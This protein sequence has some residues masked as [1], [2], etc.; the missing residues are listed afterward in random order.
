MGSPQERCVLASLLMVA[1]ESVSVEELKR[2]VWDGDP[3]P[4]AGATLESIVS[5][6]RRR[7]S[8]AGGRV[9]ISFASRAY[10]IEVDPEAVDLL[11]FRRL[12]A[13]ARALAQNGGP[14]AAVDLLVEAEGLWR[15][16]PLGEFDG[17]WAAALRVRFQEERR[18][19]RET[20]IELA[21][22][23]GRH[24]DLLSDLKEPAQEDPVTEATVMSLMVALYRSRR[25]AES[26]QV[27]H[28]TR[29]RLRDEL[30]LSPS[31]EPEAL[32]DRTLRRDTALLVP[33][34]QRP[35]APVF[36]RRPDN[37]LRS[38]AEF[39]GRERELGLI[40]GGSQGGGTA[41]PLFVV[42][43]MPGI[44]KTALAVHAAHRLKG[45]FPMACCIWTCGR[46]TGKGSPHAIRR[47][48]S[49]SFCGR[50]ARTTRCPRGSTSAPPAGVRAWSGAG[51]S[52]CWTTPGTP[53]GS[54]PCFRGTR[55]VAWS[56]PAGIGWP[57]ARRRHAR[58]AERS[59]G[60]GM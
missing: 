40:L 49:P 42:H 15:G 12:C 31:P 2:R 56:S 16:E 55:R 32:H 41:L 47:T 6:L 23:L 36:T 8:V 13:E 3:P 19:A 51:C 33:Q 34:L 59:P 22:E 27:Y 1:N 44:G 48:P 29:R 53:R 46:T 17:S 9:D 50:S 21:L 14:E 5:R 39:T 4:T 7:L 18:R 54:G 30:G 43:G 58:S 26:L 24:A 25:H 28:R 37:M 38:T 60:R 52:S 57:R 11:R 45:V 10:R 20:R 35:V